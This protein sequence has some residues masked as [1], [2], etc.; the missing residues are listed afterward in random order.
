MIIEIQ[1]RDA[2]ANDWMES[3]FAQDTTMLG[4]RLAIAEALLGG[5]PD[6]RATPAQ[7]PARLPARSGHLIINKLPPLNPP[8][9]CREQLGSVLFRAASREA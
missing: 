8:P 7:R 2:Q 4:V 1:S 6:G 9:P 5:D 3:L